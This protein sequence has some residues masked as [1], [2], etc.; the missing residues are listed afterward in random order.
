[1]RD[2]LRNLLR[3][4]M[5][6]RKLRDKTIRAMDEAVRGYHDEQ[7]ER[8]SALQQELAQL[9]AEVS[10]LRESMDK[11]TSEHAQRVLDRVVEFEIRSRRDIVYAAD[12]RA[13][14]ESAEFVREHMPTA[15]RFTRPLRTLEHALTLAPSGGMALEFGV[16]SGQ[17]LRIISE[18]RDGQVYGFDSFEGLPEDWRTDFEAGAFNTDKLPEVPGAELVV[19][20]FDDVLPGFLARH[21]GTVDFLH[22]DS[23]LHSSAET[24]LDQVGPRLR[25]G[26]VIVFDEY[27]NYPGWQRHEHRAWQEYVE[28]TGTKFSYLGYTHDNEQVVVQVDET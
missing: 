19:G 28:R 2:R 15:R 11:A 20:W 18:S 9:R 27:F 21:P 14:Q 4:D 26:S 12:Q 1:M 13:T 17:T 25:P 8:L 6:R 16:Y 5:L 23:D 24:V 3:A 10:Q 22:V 7:S